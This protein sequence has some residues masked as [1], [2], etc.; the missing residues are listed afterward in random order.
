MER[1]AAVTQCPGELSEPL[2]FLML[3]HGSLGVGY[4]HYDL[5][6]VREILLRGMQV[7][8]GAGMPA[9]LPIPGNAA[10]LQGCK[11]R[12]MSPGTSWAEQ[13]GEQAPRQGVFAGPQEEWVPRK[14]A[15]HRQASS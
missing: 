10:S 2:T 11:G 6:E 4:S 3:H 14:N 8:H 5:V 15:K 12:V 7:Q 13:A 9:K 1:P